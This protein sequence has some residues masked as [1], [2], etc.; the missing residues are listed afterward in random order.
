MTHNGDDS[1]SRRR[2]A[3]LLALIL[4]I[5][6]GAGVGTITEFEFG[7]LLKP[8]SETTPIPTQTPVE[9]TVEG[10]VE[11]TPTPVTTPEP[12]QPTPT[13]EESNE[14]GDAGGGGSGGG[15]G[16]SD[17]QATVSLES[18]GEATFLDANGVVPTQS[19]TESMML[20]NGGDRAGRLALAAVRINDSENGIVDAEAPV[21]DSPNEG[22]LSEAVL[23][24]MRFHYP[25]GDNRTV[26]GSDSSY[27]TLA[28][29]TNSSTPEKKVAPGDRVSVE[30]DWQIE[31]NAGNEIQSDGTVFDAIF[32]LRAPEN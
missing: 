20:T 30:L 23:V 9:T 15:G 19:G 25:D 14:N 7:D 2:R 11:S 24:R 10:T 17:E 29:L 5:L 12:T 27:V 13:E 18:P 31:R 32:E 6:L 28:S 22:E 1:G 4:L 26:V 21:D 8:V 3:I 16:A